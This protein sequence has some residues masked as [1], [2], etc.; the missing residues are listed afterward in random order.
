MSLLYAVSEEIKK[1]I[2]TFFDRCFSTFA[3]NFF[4]AIQPF[5]AMH[6]L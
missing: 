3:G 5:P 4:I 2:I 1:F 6:S